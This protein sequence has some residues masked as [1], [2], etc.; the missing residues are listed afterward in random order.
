M[1]SPEWVSRV[2]PPTTMVR[3]TIAQQANSHQA[4][5]RCEL[6][7]INCDPVSRFSAGLFR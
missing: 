1:D 3:N 2:M 7:V 4:T 5:A 6:L